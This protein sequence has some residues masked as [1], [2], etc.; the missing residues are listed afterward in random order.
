MLGR[1]PAVL[2]FVERLARRRELDP[3]RRLAH[4]LV[5]DLEARR[6]RDLQEMAFGLEAQA[7]RDVARQPEERSWAGGHR[8]VATCARDPALEQV[9]ALVLFMV[10][11]ERR[12]SRRRLEVK[13]AQRA[14][15]LVT[16]RLDPHQP[17]EITGPRGP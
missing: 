13:P 6:D 7:V 14:A 17:P 1:Q 15:G 3:R 5:E 8:L 9:P 4:L 12:L 16:P 11:V 10:D 2:L